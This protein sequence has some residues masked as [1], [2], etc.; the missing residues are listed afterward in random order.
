MVWD[1]QTKQTAQ[2]FT[3]VMICLRRLCLCSL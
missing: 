3:K 1:K 2:L